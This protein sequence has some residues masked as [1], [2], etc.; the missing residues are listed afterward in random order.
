MESSELYQGP[1]SILQKPWSEQADKRISRKRGERGQKL[2]NKHQ[3]VS[4]CVLRHH[5]PV[6]SQKGCESSVKKMQ[7]LSRNLRIYRIS[8]SFTLPATSLMLIVYKSP[9]SPSDTQKFASFSL[10][11]KFKLPRLCSFTKW[12]LNASISLMRQKWAEDIFNV[13]VFCNF[14][15]MSHCWISNMEKSEKD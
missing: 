14:A 6:H 5:E 15:L 7:N 9:S 1:W 2:N 12:E 8:K 4:L 11:T 10:K 3:G 13:Q